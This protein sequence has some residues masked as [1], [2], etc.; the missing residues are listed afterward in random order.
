ME[1]FGSGYEGSGAYGVDLGNL[2]VRSLHSRLSD[3]TAGR[4][5]AFLAGT[6]Q[7]PDSLNSHGYSAYQDRLIKPPQAIDLN[8]AAT[9]SAPGLQILWTGEG[10]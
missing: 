8:E 5:G 6:V 4:I 3:G 10:C 2:Q 7:Q 1:I 9:I